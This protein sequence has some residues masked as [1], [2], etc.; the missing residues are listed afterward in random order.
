M[1]FTSYYSIDIDSNKYKDSNMT[2]NNSDFNN[3]NIIFNNNNNNNNDD[4]KNI[5]IYIAL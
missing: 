1:I 2:I 4:D 5:T 3:T